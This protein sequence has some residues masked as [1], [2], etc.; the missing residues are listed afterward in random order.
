MTRFVKSV[1]QAQ[2]RPYITCVVS[3]QEGTGGI[4]VGSRELL[5]FC[6]SL[7][8][9]VCCNADGCEAHMEESE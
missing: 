2:K 5:I 3:V 6:G 1:V 4:V 9:D 8:L 7:R